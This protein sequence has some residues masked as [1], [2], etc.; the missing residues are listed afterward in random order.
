MRRMVAKR[1]RA[2]PGSWLGPRIMPAA[3]AHAP[4]AGNC[5]IGG[6]MRG[7]VMALCALLLG[8]CADLPLFHEP[9]RLAG[10]ATTPK[11]SVDFVKETRPEKTEFTS[12]GIEPGHP[13]DKPR[14]QAGVKQ[15]QTELEAQR[16]TGHAIL[17][18]LSPETANAQG[19]KS[20]EKGKAKDAAKRKGKDE[21]DANGKARATSGASAETPAPQ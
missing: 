8:A 16:D 13:P 9:A 15:L 12:V 4:L 17:Q 6:V 3:R 14:D 1:A 7:G 2:R 19:Q 20:T 11:E 10:F 21:A 5:I 18:K